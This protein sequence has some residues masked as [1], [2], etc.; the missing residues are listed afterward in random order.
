MMVNPE[1]PVDREKGNSEREGRLTA[2]RN[3][4]SVWT[5]W[6]WP[7][8]K[9]ELNELSKQLKEKRSLLDIFKRNKG[10]NS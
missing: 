9:Y 10:G 5:G 8:A 2:W 1:T 7:A 3:S 6:N 4:D